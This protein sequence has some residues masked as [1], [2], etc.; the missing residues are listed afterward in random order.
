MTDD[1]PTPPSPV[2]PGPCEKC[3]G[4]AACWCRSPDQQGAWPP[5]TMTA[6]RETDIRLDLASSTA[7]HYPRAVADDLLAELDATRN[8]WYA[9]RTRADAAERERDQHFLDWRIANDSI[10]NAQAAQQAAESRL[11][12]ALALAE[13]AVESLTCEG[14]FHRKADLH[15]AG[16]PC[17]AIVRLRARLATLKGEAHD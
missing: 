6:E 16:D 17:P 7:H 8:E 13:E 11:A 15:G 9:Q 10:A 1:T 12:E 5:L 2:R 4:L 14:V 3:G